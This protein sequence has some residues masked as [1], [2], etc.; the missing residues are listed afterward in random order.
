MTD[1]PPGDADNDQLSGDGL[2]ASSKGPIK[3]ILNN[4][5]ELAQWLNQAD[6]GKV[7]LQF[8]GPEHRSMLSR[9]YNDISPIKHS[10]VKSGIGSFDN[11]EQLEKK[12]KPE[13]GERNTDGGLL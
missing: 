4:K 13:V 1:C 6:K 2:M 9:G 7:D 8:Y 3:K 11:F 10:L 12:K 5:D